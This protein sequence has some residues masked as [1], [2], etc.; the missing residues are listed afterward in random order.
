MTGGWQRLWN[1]QVEEPE[2]PQSPMMSDLEVWLVF[3]L[4]FGVGIG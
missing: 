1:L 3:W 4:V 2:H